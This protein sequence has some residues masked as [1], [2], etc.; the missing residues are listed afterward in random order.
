MQVQED[1]PTTPT[2]KTAPRRK[3]PSSTPT[4]SVNGDQASEKPLQ[5][6]DLEEKPLVDGQLPDGMARSSPDA[7]NESSTTATTSR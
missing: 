5:K 1:K 2:K 7:G 4:P 6:R 3:T